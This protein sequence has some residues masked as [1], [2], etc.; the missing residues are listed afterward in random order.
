MISQ[1]PIEIINQICQYNCD[2]DN[3]IFILKFHE[4]GIPHFILNKN[5]KT[6]NII[7][8]KVKDKL[9]NPLIKEFIRLEQLQLF[10]RKQIDLQYH[11]YIVFI[12]TVCRKLV[13]IDFDL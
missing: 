11:K 8:K 10:T 7:H 12:Y 3:D 4:N 2:L 6:C 13:P 5:S 9:Q 1:L